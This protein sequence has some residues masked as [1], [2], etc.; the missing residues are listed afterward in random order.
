MSHPYPHIISE[1]CSWSFAALEPFRGKA[2]TYG[3]AI[4][5]GEKYYFIPKKYWWDEFMTDLMKSG[6][7]FVVFDMRRVIDW[8]LGTADVVDVK[9]LCGGEKSLPQAMRNFMVDSY[10]TERLNDVDRSMAANLRA[11]KTAQVE[12][13]D[14]TI[15]N[16]MT[17]TF[18]ENYLK[19]RAQAIVALFSKFGSGAA[20]DE[21]QRREKFIRAVHEVE[22][23][24]IRIDRDFVDAQLL[25]KQE[26]ADVKCFR[27]M[28]A[29]Y[30]NGYVTALYN[31]NG[32][33]TGRL[34]SE[35]GFGAMGIPH[36]PCRKAIVS[37]FE[38]GKI[39]TFD[40][41]AI[42]YRSIVGSIGGDF[43]ELY[44][45]QDDF[46]RRTAL[47]LFKDVDEVRRNTIKFIS[48]VY[49]YGGSE[50]TLSGKTGLSVE[51]V[52]E[53]LSILDK[54]LGPIKEFREKLWGLY[55]V[56][57][58]IDVPGV[59]RYRAELDEGMHPGKLLGIYAQGFS[60]YVF[61]QAFTNVHNLLKTSNGSCII[62]PVHD[63][64]VIDMHP[65]DIEQGL[66]ER[67]MEAMSS[68]P[69]E[70]FKV[71]YKKG[72]SYGEVE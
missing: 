56:Q 8:P 4:S 63:E 17:P 7:R 72:G 6:A 38:S 16:T 5:N 47:F 57:G 2:G 22:L 11:L 34:R 33:K 36:G 53:V 21:W 71:N 12:V 35:G 42:D 14:Q 70:G 64:L 10:L 59:G 15:I 50:E 27:S 46:H 24:G 43:A 55:Q 48:Y 40:Y 28:Q 52:K 62:F 3:V 69:C 20:F 51:K 68:G 13:N 67:I 45:G 31:V 41:N 39:Y 30:K 23:N 54:H 44:R 9:T 26:P 19:T 18:F 32:T 66:P 60:S 49:I 37:R 61:E 29:L 1:I 58:Y 65:T 25:K